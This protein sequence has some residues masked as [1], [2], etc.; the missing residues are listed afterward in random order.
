MSLTRIPA[1][2]RRGLISISRRVSG[3]RGRLTVFGRTCSGAVER[4]ED[5]TAV[6]VAVR[7][8]VMVA[9]RGAY[10]RRVTVVPTTAPPTTDPCV[11]SL[12]Y[13]RSESLVIPEA[14][15]AAGRDSKGS[16]IKQVIAHEQ[17]EVT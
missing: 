7:G 9:I 3:P 15:G 17:L 1:R 11:L 5:A 4:A 13:P 12:C 16:S 10:V 14:H 8:I 2:A 6:V